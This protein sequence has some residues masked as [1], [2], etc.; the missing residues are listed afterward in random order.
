[1]LVQFHFHD[2][3]VIDLSTDKYLSYR[4]SAPQ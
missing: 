1:M 4:A 3:Q 2:R